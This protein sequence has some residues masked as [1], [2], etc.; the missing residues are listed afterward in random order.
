MLFRSIADFCARVDRRVVNRRAIE[1]LIK[2]GAFDS[3]ER[4]RAALLA[5][6]GAAIETAEQGAAH[7]QQTSLFGTAFL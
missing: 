7:A 3:V 1:A 6:L 5:S 4:N 2:A